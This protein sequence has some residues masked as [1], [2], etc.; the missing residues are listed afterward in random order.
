[1]L[2]HMNQADSEIA[3]VPQ[4]V[5]RRDFV[6]GLIAP[7]LISVAIVFASAGTGFT[8][9]VLAVTLLLTAVWGILL[10]LRPRNRHFGAGLLLGSVLAIP[11]YYVF[12]LASYAFFIRE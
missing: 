2:R 9:A 6:V 4:A 11:L 10:L 1:M 3:R 12:L 5:R 7:I 8:D